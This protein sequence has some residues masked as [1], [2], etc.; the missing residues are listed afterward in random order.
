MMNITN[1]GRARSLSAPRPSISFLARTLGF[2]LVVLTFVLS[3][4][5]DLSAAE[6]ID[7][8]RISTKYR[9]T[10]SFKRISEF[11][12]GKENP[13]RNIIFRTQPEIRDGFYFSF[14]VEAPKGSTVPAG[15]VVLFVYTPKSTEPTE[16]TFELAAQ[17]KRWVPVLIGLTGTDWEDPEANPVAWRLE[18]RTPTGEV[19]G[20]KNSFLWILPDEDQ[21]Q[22][23]AN[24][25][26]DDSGG[27]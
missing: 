18:Y 17:K 27:N 26:R 23:S 2:L 6:P 13:G 3:G 15:A 1:N 14:R 10:G 24:T 11:F 9:E 19:T 25:E 22:S 21:E 20:F 5:S 7:L 16:Y 4:V 8:T 12:T